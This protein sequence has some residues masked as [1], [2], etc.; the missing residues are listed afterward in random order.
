MF[1]GN[2][3]SQN[4]RSYIGAVLNHRPI[5]EVESEL[6]SKLSTKFLKGEQFAGVSAALVPAYLYGVLC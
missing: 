5:N 2:D 6:R 3:I 4:I 1:A